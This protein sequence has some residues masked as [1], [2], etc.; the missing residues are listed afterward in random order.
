MRCHCCWVWVW[1]HTTGSTRAHLDDLLAALIARDAQ[2]SGREPQMRLT[3][4]GDVHEE[5]AQLD[6]CAEEPSHLE[7]AV[8]TAEPAEGCNFIGNLLRLIDHADAYKRSTW[9]ASQAVDPLFDE[10]CIQS[11]ALDHFGRDL[12]LDAVGQR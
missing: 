8:A 1:V 6:A 3:A 5:K 12:G 10:S 2:R 9:L 4:K 11:V 7:D